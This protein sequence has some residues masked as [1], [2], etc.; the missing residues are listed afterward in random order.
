MTDLILFNANVITMAPEN[1]PENLPDDLG[2][3]LVA[4][5][6]GKI[7]A[8][9]SENNL[10]ALKTKDTKLIDCKGKT[11]LPGFYDAHCHLHGLA[12]SLVTL[13]LSPKNNI[14][15]IA[16]IQS[17][18]N[19][20]SKKLEPGTWIRGRGYNE[21]YLAEKRHP[22]GKDLDK[23]SKHHPVKL[24]H[25]TGHAH[26][27]NSMALD[28]TNITIKTPEPSHGVIERDINTGEPN[29]LFFEMGDMLSQHI[30]KIDDH[31]LEKGIKLANHYLISHGVTSIQDASA[32]NSISHW[33][34]FC[35][36]EEKGVIKPRINML[37]GVDCFE[38]THKDEFCC[39]VD[40]NRF[41]LSGVKI[42]LDDING[43]LHPS[44]EELNSMVLKI[45]R[46][47]MQVA[48]HAVEEDAVK[49][50]CT[51]I[52]YA[53]EKLPKHNHRHHIEHCSVCPE[54][55]AKRI[56]ASNIIV[57]TQPTFIYYNG[58]RY[59]KTVPGNQLK[60]LYPVKTL[61]QNGVNIAGSSDF[62]VT[63]ANP[64]IGIYAAVSR[65]AETGDNVLPE[66][67]VTV[68]DALNM[69]TIS[70]AH[71][72]F[73]ETI[74]GSIVTGKL[75]DM[76]LLSHNPLAVPIDDIKNIS[77]EMTIINGEVVWDNLNT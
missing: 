52:E 5:K 67:S 4:V 18:I 70:G 14:R 35:E 73:K 3:K 36:W 7:F 50:A 16:D 2:K 56:A 24:T 46:A 13:D 30:P 10:K 77:V 57:V 31:E 32:G 25:R 22:T 6:E 68:K 42:I 43:R 39:P 17:K 55:Q 28:I 60:H 1:L 15:S 26:V 64:L 63:P 75:A 76:V 71:A 66:E 49:S 27:L 51:A 19:S 58:D 53:L 20:L 62:P 65:K 74:K 21:F 54:N 8:V 38:T 37:I 40:K 41:C 34:M 45:H 44:Q 11:L 48:I 47:G 59:L 9:T 61:I 69:Y 29:G 72:T 12:E 23:V 33:N